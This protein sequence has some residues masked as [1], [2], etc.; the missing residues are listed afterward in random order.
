MPGDVIN[1]SFF[2][3]PAFAGVALI[4]IGI[5]LVLYFF[6]PSYHSFYPRCLFHQTTGLFCP[7]CGSLRAL[8]ELL[9]GHFAAAVHLNAL[10]V[11]SLPV[12]GWLALRHFRARLAGA[13]P[14]PLFTPGLLWTGLAVLLLFS[15]LR[16]LPFA[17]PWLA[18]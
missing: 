2:R 10:L 6:D 17:R 11:V 18:P 12:A 14:A 1:K 16:N 15:L 4:I 3:V 9:H 13:L 7:G 5:T 8:H